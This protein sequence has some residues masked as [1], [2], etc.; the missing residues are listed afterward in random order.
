MASTT[1]FEI[2]NSLSENQNLHDEIIK[3]VSDFK[4]QQES[5]RIKYRLLY[6]LMAIGLPIPLVL[7]WILRD[8]ISPEFALFMLYLILLGEWF[9]YEYIYSRSMTSTLQWHAFSTGFDI[10]IKVMA[11]IFLNHYAHRFVSSSSSSSSSF[12]RHPIIITRLTPD[13][14]P[15]ASPSENDQIIVWNK[16]LDAFNSDNFV[17]HHV[18]VNESVSESIP[19]DEISGNQHPNSSFVYFLDN[20]S[21]PLSWETLQN[22][23]GPNSIASVGGRNPFTNTIVQTIIKKK[24]VYE[25]IY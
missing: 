25:R 19:T 21:Y 23:Y 20:T 12:R 9:I 6:S 17:N 4:E 2:I 15:P 7:F 11:P 13:S 8:S 1:L 24:L 22:L 3:L 18:V 14:P 16:A 5:R 10:C